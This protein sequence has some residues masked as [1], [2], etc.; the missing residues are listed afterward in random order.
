M[1]YVKLN[2]ILCASLVLFGLHWASA[3][4]SKIQ[5]YDFLEVIVIQKANNR[6][7]V[8]RIKVEEQESLEGKTVTVDA[9]EDLKTTSGLL[10]YMNQNQWELLDRHAIVSEEN[11]PVWWSYIFR[12]KKNTAF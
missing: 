6:G 12:K 2:F 3:Q 7:K 10:R 8:K 11:D 9:I 5:Q 1:K 4:D